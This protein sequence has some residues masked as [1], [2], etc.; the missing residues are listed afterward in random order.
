MKHPISYRPDI[1]GLRAFAIIAVI[2]FHFCGSLLPSGYVGV[3]VFFVISGF[4]ITKIILKNQAQNNFS[5]TEFYLRRIRRI[6]PALF[7]M[8]FCSF[9]LGLLIL[10]SGDMM[11]FTKGLSFASLQ[12][13]NL[14]FQR[15]V[16]YFNE[17]RNFEP[18]L[19]TWSLGV[20]EQFYLLMPLVIVIFSRFAK[21]K[22]LP[23]YALVGLSLASLC[24]SQYLVFANQKVA[25]FSLFSR[26][27]ELGVG[28]LAAFANA[29]KLSNRTNNLLGCLGAELLVISLFA[30]KQSNFPGF[31]ALAPCLGAALVIFT[32]ESRQT[33]TAKFFSNKI[34]VFI[35]KISYSL[36][37][38]HLPV[39]VF[40]KEYTNQTT[41]NFS[42]SAA[43]VCAI[44]LISYCSWRFI[45]TPFRKSYV[46]SKENRF[47][48]N[49]F[50]HPFCVALL[51]ILFFTS[52]K[53]VS[54]KTHGFSFRLAQSEI[55]TIPNLDQYAASKKA[56]LCG[57]D[58]T[59]TKFP[60]IEECIVGK[61]TKNFEVAIFGDSH[62]GHFSPSVINWAAKRGMSTAT[63]YFS[64][65]VPLLTSDHQLNK[66]PRCWEYREKVLQILK[67]RP[68]IKY[69]FLGSIWAANSKEA[70]NNKELFRENFAATLQAVTSLNKKFIILGRVPDFNP[71]A[72]GLSPF[73]C[74]ERELTPMQKIISIPSPNC[75]EIPLAKLQQQQDFANLMQN[76]ISKYRNVFYFD[77]F[78]YF[79]DAEK[80][81]AVKNG[82]LLYADKGHIN[83]NGAEYISAG[84]FASARNKA[85]NFNS[86]VK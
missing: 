66:T 41:L 17:G 72:S 50:K 80:C 63:F 23:L 37:L 6:F 71:N 12:I 20:E 44:F 58:K 56:D 75:S 38:W 86:Q 53:S 82:K 35:G 46:F 13:S 3:D 4:L 40:Y 2:V 16:D 84:D 49:L 34:L 67:E 78:P 83:A 25:F 36:Y 22:N 68:H 29:N 30:I 74:F 48:L 43:L 32:G 85:D 76:E 55:L 27:W 62:A 47:S 70:E 60:D 54:K 31:V 24:A 1:D 26:F 21:N 79:C 19:H 18:L 9:L 61:N 64:A 42:T 39:L 8:L 15:N 69:V 10:T 28:C 14:F 5:F 57:M 73:K 77:S 7:A 45:E 51:C 59:N 11:W 52:L 81:S 65:C 33:L